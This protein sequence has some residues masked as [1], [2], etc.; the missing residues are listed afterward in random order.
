MVPICTIRA[1]LQDKSSLGPCRSG[2]LNEYEKRNAHRVIV[3]INMRASTIPQI[4][5][6]VLSEWGYVELQTA[7]GKV[8]VGTEQWGFE[9]GMAVPLYATC[10]RGEEFADDVDA[11]RCDAAIEPLNERWQIILFFLI[12]LT[13]F[14]AMGHWGRAFQI[15]VHGPTKCVARL[16]I[17]VCLQTRIGFERLFERSFPEDLP[18]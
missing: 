18:D 16:P 12:C 4:R 1:S 15:P 14:C 7:E 10:R 9:K 2:D 8:F 5:E 11:E 3:P 6:I 17:T 13:S